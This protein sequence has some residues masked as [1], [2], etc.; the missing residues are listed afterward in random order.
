M[1]AKVRTRYG[2]LRYGRCGLGHVFVRMGMADELSYVLNG[3]AYV[4]E[5]DD[6]GWTVLHWAAQRGHMEICL[7]LLRDHAAQ[8][9]ETDNGGY[10]ALHCVAWNGHVGICRLLLDNGA[11]INQEDIIGNTALSIAKSEEV[12][13]LLIERGA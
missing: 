4:G 1:K 9:N 7:I 11:D 3:G 6:N 2:R 12:R 5:K 13:K 8:I 10:T